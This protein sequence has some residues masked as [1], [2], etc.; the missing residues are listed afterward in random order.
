MF[1]NHSI[2]A[3]KKI[4]YLKTH[5]KDWW[6][7]L[8]RTLF[9][10]TEK[11]QSKTGNYIPQFSIK[12]HMVMITQ[13]SYNMRFC[14]WT[15]KCK[16]WKLVYILIF[17]IFVRDISIIMNTI[18]PFCPLSFTCPFLFYLINHP[19]FVCRS[20]QVF[21]KFTGQTNIVCTGYIFITICV[22]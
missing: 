22:S 17:H 2:M 15:T 16:W 9:H 12:S 14:V 3:Q 19:M 10:L 20:M 5:N 18:F 7:L 1:Q 11:L 6:V 13:P 4:N 21:L 8:W